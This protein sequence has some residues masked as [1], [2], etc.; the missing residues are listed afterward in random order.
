MVML[1]REQMLGRELGLGELA[2]GEPEAVGKVGDDVDERLLIV[3]LVLLKA[4]A[5]VCDSIESASDLVLVEAGVLLLAPLQDPCRPLRRLTQ[6]DTLARLTFM[7][8]RRV[9]EKA[10]SVTTFLWSSAPISDLS[11]PSTS[12][13]PSSSTTRPSSYPE[14]SSAASI[15]SNRPPSPGSILTVRLLTSKQAS[16]WIPKAFSS[17]SSSS[18]QLARRQRA[19]LHGVYGSSRLRGIVLLLP[20]PELRS[21]LSCFALKDP[22]RRAEGLGQLVLTFEDTSVATSTFLRESRELV[23]L[24]VT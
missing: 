10:A 23:E 21:Y 5:C 17:S 7:G 24:E 14:R 2:D 18:A 4:A 9:V 13:L 11:S 16:A 12:D 6:D 3:L 1:T 8:P 20:H 22:A 15:P 19:L